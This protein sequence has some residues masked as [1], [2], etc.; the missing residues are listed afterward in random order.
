MDRTLEELVLVTSPEYKAS[1]DFQR[2][3]FVIM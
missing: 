1:T 3:K 2:F